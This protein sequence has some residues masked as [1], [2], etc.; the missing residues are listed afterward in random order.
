MHP[1]RQ[2]AESFQPGT[3]RVVRRAFGRFAL[4]PPCIDSREM[5]PFDRDLEVR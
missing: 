3:D 2:L 1:P 5:Q 4:D